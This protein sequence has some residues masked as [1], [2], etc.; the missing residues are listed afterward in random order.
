MQ[1]KHCKEN[2]MKK[3][4]CLTIAMLLILTS[5][6][7][8]NKTS[9]QASITEKQFEMFTTDMTPS[10][11]NKYFAIMGVKSE[12]DTF[13]AIINVFSDIGDAVFSFTVGNID[14]FFGICWERDTYNIWI[15]SADK[16]MT[17]YE[18][19]NEEWVLN[20]SASLPEYMK[21]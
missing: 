5:C 10:Y 19:N 9:Q 6:K 11:D 15:L 18:Y 1:Q 21:Q 20:E 17:C 4:L 2:V 16:G 13:L 12:N 3:L 7:E 14:N 8:N